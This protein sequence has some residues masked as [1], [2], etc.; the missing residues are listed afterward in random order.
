KTK[1]PLPESLAVI[2]RGLKDK[3]LKQSAAE[4]E[5]DLESGLSLSEAL[6]RQKDT[7]PALYAS[8]VKAGEESGDLPGILAALCEY[9]YAMWDLERKMKTALVY[10]AV[11]G[12]FL[13][14]YLPALVA[15]AVPTFTQV[16]G[17][18]AGLPGPTR[19]I[20]GFSHFITSPYGLMSLLGIPLVWFAYRVL[21]RTE[22]GK[23]IFDQLKLAIPLFGTLFRGA[24]MWRFSRT[25]GILLKAGVPLVDSLQLVRTTSRN[26]VIESAIANVQRSV[27]QGEKF[28]EQCERTGVFPEMMTWMLTM[29]EAQGTLN[30]TLTELADFYDLEVGLSCRKIQSVIGPILVL[31]LGVIVGFIVL[32]L[33]MPV[34][35]LGETIR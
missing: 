33:Y 6:E 19:L 30:E 5:K 22:K 9:S 2:S 12:A 7:F 28:G 10:P 27:S 1:L 35:S 8:M 13:L 24:E 20:I 32:S 34:F 11:V 25:L 23:G 21:R 29:G 26:K 4:I 14:F 31:I 17:S 18:I 3:P 15:F 16:Y